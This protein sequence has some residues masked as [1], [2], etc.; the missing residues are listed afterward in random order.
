[1]V[2]FGSSLRACRR[3]GWEAAYLDYETLKLL[4]SQI[5]AV[6][7]EEGHR[8]QRNATFEVEG[9]PQPTSDY[10][11]ELFLE[12]DSDEAYASVDDGVDDDDYSTSAGGSATEDHP[13][14]HGLHQG[15][16]QGLHRRAHSSNKPFFVSYSDDRSSSE[17]EEVKNDGCGAG[18]SYSLSSWTTWEKQK[19]A[20]NAKNKKRRNLGTSALE[21]ED[22]FYMQR[23][24]VNTTNNA[25]FLA[26]DMNSRDNN[27]TSGRSLLSAPVMMHASETTSLLAPSTPVQPGSS[28]YTFSTASDSST[29]PRPVAN[30]NGGLGNS[31]VD[32]AIMSNMGDVATPQGV[33]TQNV[34]KKQEEKQQRKRR[35]RRLRA[36]RR[37][38]EKKV[39]RHLRLAHSKARP[40]VERFLGLLRAETEKVL[41]F[42][43]S[44]LGELADTAGSLRFPSLDDQDHVV[45]NLRT[46]PATAFNYPLAE[47]GLHPS[48]SSS[49]D[50]DAGGQGVFTWSD[51]SSGDEDSRGSQIRASPRVFSGIGADDAPVRSVRSKSTPQIT[52][53]KGITRTGSE[54]YPVEDDKSGV[55]RQILHFAELRQRRPIFLR[56]DQILGE[57]ML[58]ISAVE[59]ADGYTTV[60]VELMHVIRFILVNL[61][62]V[63]KIC[64]KH[65]RLLMQRMLGGYYNRTRGSHDLLDRYAHIE[66]AQTLG[67]LLARVSGDVYD[68]HPALISHYSHYR[69]VGVYDRKIQK[70]A[71][72]R[73]V[74][75][76]SSCL[77]LALSEYEVARSRA[78]ALTKLN[79]PQS[80]SKTPKRSGGGGSNFNPE[81]ILQPVFSEDEGWEGPPT[82]ES[83]ISLTRLR[84]TV[85]SIFALREAARKK[86]DHYGAYLSRSMLTF[87]GRP[88]LGEGFDGC[89][90]ETLDFLVAYNP[91][92]ALLLDTDTLH[93]GLY[94]GQWMRVPMSDVMIRTLA[95]ALTCPGYVSK[96]ALQEEVVVASAV[97]VDPESRNIVLKR[98]LKGQKAKSAVERTSFSIPDLP[99]IAFGLN[100]TTCFLY[101]VS[102]DLPQRF[103]SGLM[104]CLT[105]ISTLS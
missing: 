1:M 64:K 22:A 28:M 32:V 69:L 21:E 46:N 23:S 48:D 97:S 47:G 99:S 103:V 54:V 89:S 5:E 71:N 35:R 38:K 4:L 63:K 79:S 81:H 95:T 101:M 105:R 68:A 75:V 83:N 15:P 66:D 24:S 42:A 45:R 51:S 44:R 31:A 50:E 76:V 78:D 25:F 58:L 77:A 100:R 60:G 16:N 93:R 9:A 73:T 61:V 18:V 37:A 13:H 27:N 70:L 43:Q 96:S 74:Q 10:R 56:N 52:C 39:P 49:D 12:S 59:E 41:L 36:M 91:D 90:R 53:H 87:T 65:D 92:S 84:Y 80:S 88:V 19:D 98:L 14:P 85:T 20:D 82:T 67:G 86:V 34:A 62:A 17:D 102:I 3:P 26:G 55:L 104:L 11:D 40:I 72:S 57:D 94:N 8:R 6:Y 2:G 33:A 29:P 7:E 30:R